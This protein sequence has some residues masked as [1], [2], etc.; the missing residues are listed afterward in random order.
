MSAEKTL[1]PQ[2]MVPEKLFLLPLFKKLRISLLL[3]LFASSIPA[4]SNKPSNED[5]QRPFIVTTTNFIRDAVEIIGDDKIRVISLMG[6]GVDPHLYRATPGDFQYMERSDLIFY[7][8]LFLEGR[9]SEILD[10]MGD[11]SRAVTG[12]IPPGK[13]ISASN[14]GGTYDPHVWFD[15]E[16]WMHAISDIT[17]ALSEMLPDNR[18]EFRERKQHY[19]QELRDL[20]RYTLERIQSI[21]ENRRVLITAHDAFQYFS[22]AYGM[23]VRGLQGLSTAAEFGIQDVTNLVSFI[24]ERQIPAIFVET[25][26]STR[27]IE[28]VI[29]GVRQRGYQVKNGGTLFSDSMGA[30]GTPEGTYTGM[31]RHNVDTIVNALTDQNGI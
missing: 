21:P 25:G 8:G 26:V 9:L 28:S 4:C 29:T 12:S 19:F 1:H 14:Y 27:A 31:F 18:D 30:D 20:H 2:F 22:R 17:E 3:L 15:I 7:N 5:D 24:M 23:E 10:R 16:L 13:L 6:P 11:K